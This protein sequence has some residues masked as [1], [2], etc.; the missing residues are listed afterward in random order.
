MG[1][2]DSGSSAKGA[3][4]D[5]GRGGGGGDSGDDEGDRGGGKGSDGESE[6][7]WQW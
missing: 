6:C 5:L 7:S 1:G 3:D 4:Y 2:E